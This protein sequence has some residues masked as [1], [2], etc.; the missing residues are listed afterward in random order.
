ML[1]IIIIAGI[2]MTISLILSLIL[3]K[4]NHKV[5][6]KVNYKVNYKVYFIL[7]K[8]FKIILSIGMVSLI[9][10]AV[11]SFLYNCYYCDKT[12]EFITGKTTLISLKFTNNNECCYSYKDNEGNTIIKKESDY[13]I[14]EKSIKKPYIEYCKYRI[15]LQQQNSITYKLLHIGSKGEDL[16]P[17]EKFV[18]PKGYNID[19]R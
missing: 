4:V 1:L 17:H 11:I 15:P 7:E 10:A 3:S 5:N 9:V 8:I 16:I 14:R 18:V 13:V 12:E 2:I 19:E 6:H